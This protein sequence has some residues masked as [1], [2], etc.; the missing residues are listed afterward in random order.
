MGEFN[1]ANPPNIYRYKYRGSVPLQ[2]SVCCPLNRTIIMKP[3][4]LAVLLLLA[5]AVIVSGD[6]TESGIVSG[7]P[8]ESGKSRYGDKTCLPVIFQTLQLYK[9]VSLLNYKLR[10][11]VWRHAVK[12][13]GILV[14]ALQAKAHVAL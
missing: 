8:T 9:I 1:S 14:P 11:D 13:P 6:P 2:H 10:H 5:V 12:T 3:V 4:V 7:A